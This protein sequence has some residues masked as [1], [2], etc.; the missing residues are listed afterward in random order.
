MRKKNVCKIDLDS[1]RTTRSQ[2]NQLIFLFFFIFFLFF[3]QSAIFIFIAEHPP[4]G[5][6]IGK[7]KQRTTA[8][9]SKL[10]TAKPEDHRSN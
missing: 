2:T 1:H 6:T 10:Q 5:N 8:P 9:Q 7:H 4:K 3:E